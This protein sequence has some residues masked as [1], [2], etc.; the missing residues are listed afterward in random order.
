LI[1]NFAHILC[2]FY[3]SAIDDVE[4]VREVISEVAI[5]G[6]LGHQLSLYELDHTLDRIGRIKEGLLDSS[7][8][9][10]STVEAGLGYVDDRPNRRMDMYVSLNGTNGLSKHTNT[11][12]KN[13]E[14]QLAMVQAASII[15]PWIV[16]RKSK[17]DYQYVTHLNGWSE[18][19]DKEPFRFDSLYTAAWIG[20]TAETWAYYPPFNKKAGIPFTIGDALGPVVICDECPFTKPNKPENNPERKAFLTSPYP[21]VAQ[22]GL[23][24]ISA[25]APV[26]YNGTFLNR[27]YNDEY[28]A[29][30]GVDIE[31]E[32]VSTLL[33]V[34]KGRLT[35]GSFGLL[36]DL[37]LNVIVI[38]QDVVEMIYPPLTGYEEER[39]TYDLSDGGDSS[40]T[41]LEDR[42]N[43]TYLVSDTIIQGLTEL[44]NANW[45]SLKASL[46]KLER[47]KRDYSTLNITLTGSNHPIEYYV[48][49]ERWPYV[50]DWAMLIFAPKAEVEN[51]I[52][53]GIRLEEKS[54]KGSAS[55]SKVLEGE[56]G[57]ILIGNTSIYNDGTIDIALVPKSTPSWLRVTSSVNKKRVLKAGKSMPLDFE[58]ETD[59]LDVGTT[60]SLVS[61]LVHDD[62]YPDCF[63]NEELSLRLTIHVLP[64]DCVRITGDNLRVAD[65]SGKCICRPYS[66]E[67]GGS[68]ISYGILLP[69]LILPIL[70]I[71]FLSVHSYI[72]RKRKQGDSV[73][74]VAS[75]DLIYGE[76]PEV[77][78]RGTWG[79]VL[80]A[81]YRGTTVAVKRVIPPKK[82]LNGISSIRSSTSMKN[83]RASDDTNNDNTRRQSSMLESIKEYVRKRSSIFSS[84]D[85]NSVTKDK[86]DFDNKIEELDDNGTQDEGLKTVQHFG[87]SRRRSSLLSYFSADDNNSLGGSFRHGAGVDMVYADEENL[88]TSIL[89]TRSIDESMPL[90]ITKTKMNQRGKESGG[91]DSVATATS[92]SGHYSLSFKHLKQDFIEEMR[93]LSKLRHP[94]IVTVMGAVMSSR[95]DPLLVMEYL[96]H[97]SL[98][99]LLH[100][101]TMRFE[102]EIILPILRDVAQGLRFLHT[103]QPQIIHGDLKSANILV[104]SEFRAKVADFGF[105]AK[106]AMNNSVSGTPYWMAPELLRGEASNTTQSDV[107]SFGIVIYEVYSRLE[108][109]AGED[110]NTVIK[111]IKDP[112]INKRP[113]APVSM[114]AE[115]KTLLY[116]SCLK[117]DSSSRPSFTELD[118]F[119]KRFEAKNVDPAMLSQLPKR[120]S[121]GGALRLLDQVFP[122]HVALALREGRK[123][124]P[125]HHDCVTIFF[126]DVVGYTKLSSTMTPIKVS[127]MIDRLYQKLDS[128]SFKWGVHKLETIGDAWMG[129]TNLFEACPDDHAKRVAQ[130]A[131]EAVQVAR[132]ILIDL[133]DPS[134]GYVEIRAGFHSGSILASV[135]G[136]RLPKYTVFGDTVN[137]ASRMESTSKPGK[138]HCSERS[139]KL[140]QSQAPEIVTRCRGEITVKGKG[141]MITYWVDNVPKGNDRQMSESTVQASNK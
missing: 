127:N 108:P 96:D 134:K 88:D 136:S 101:E 107:Y 80:I 34:V 67:I 5:N 38:S 7:I 29:S 86:F 44:D 116:S 68:C 4:L 61:F 105:S 85:D 99:D 124:E 84:S 22:P 53:I 77:A 130:F 66:S 129:V 110:Y 91:Y 122:P 17:K 9:S 30:T 93:Q 74:T 79:L 25:I 118:G 109:Y 55:S 32:A 47:G 57:S 56:K 75:S 39:I 1:C 81:T 18:G 59:S 49:Y 33:D 106:K 137:T 37:E 26:Y 14:K 10:S 120:L 43:Q 13:V 126:S 100:N 12:R 76:P 45:A 41:I 92:S 82:T 64:K 11:S 63:H 140:L 48:M 131:M 114:P 23:S 58:V 8:D 20:S 6:G 89:S 19:P 133:D 35:R 24:L 73:W 112:T 40:T 78:G 60:S 28:I 16:D 111:Q 123:V 97:G 71:A 50:A 69:S 70:V 102:G 87:K 21:D 113:P 141:E 36:V 72:E 51:A 103:A 94:C 65:S 54:Y 121:T 46:A 95:E 128:L 90:I 119:L 83:R 139:A 62:S 117:E 27:S 104:D 42:R 138:V 135:V 98:Y 132:E 52:N 2:I 3:F 31:V 15:F 125:E 115:V